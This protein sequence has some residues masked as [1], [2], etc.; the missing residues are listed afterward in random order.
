MSVWKDLQRTT[1]AA[2][3]EKIGVS[4]QVIDSVAGG[5]YRSGKVVEDVAAALG[6][7]VEWLLYG[8]GAAPEWWSESITGQVSTDPPTDKIPRSAVREE[9]PV[10]TAGAGVGAF[11]MPFVGQVTAGGGYADP[12][13]D[14][15]DW[16]PV[17]FKPHWRLVRVQGTSAHPI[18]LSGQAAI[19]D[20][21]LPVRDGRMVC[22]QTTDGRA[23]LKRWNTVGDHIVL[24]GLNSGA[25]STVLHR[26]DIASVAVV[27]GTLYV[28]SVAR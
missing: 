26:S 15:A 1:F 18:L 12:S 11:S 7:S 19:V 8:V 13:Q 9:F 16:E 17:S 20:D 3:G 25:D 27:V 10:H 22:V 24:A 14:G 6:C 23:Y 5:R 2:L 4:R 21:K 28:D